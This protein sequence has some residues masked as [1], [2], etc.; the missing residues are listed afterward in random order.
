M[1]VKRFLGRWI[2]GLLV[3]GFLFPLI[4]ACSG[5]NE[6]ENAGNDNK[7]RV[8]RIGTMYG[9][10]YANDPWFRQQ[11]LELFEFSHPNITIEFVEAVSQED[12]QNGEI[13]DAV[14]AM[15][16]IMT[17]DNPPDVVM[18]NYEQMDPFVDENL[19]KPLDA[20]ITKDKF[21]I[22]GIVPSILEALKEKGDGK[23][24]A[25]APYFSSSVLVYNKKM[26][27]E[28]NISYPT[29][30]MTWD[31]VFTMA[32]SLSKDKGDGTRQYGFAFTRHQYDEPYWQMETYAAPLQLRIFD[33]E[34]E[35]MTVNS[36]SWAQVWGTVAELYRDQVLPPGQSYEDQQAF[37]ESTGPYDYDNFLSGK[38]AMS[39]AQSYDIQEFI[40]AERYGGPD[41]EM[42]DWDIVTYPVHSSAPGVGGN[43]WMDGLMGINAKAQNERDAWEFLKFINGEQFAE[44]KSRGSQYLVTR[45]KY[46][47]PIEGKE[48]NIEAFTKIKPVQ[49]EGYEDLYTKYP[50]IGQVFSLGQQKFKEVLDEKMDVSQALQ[51]WEVEGNQ[52]LED[53]RNNPQPEG[54]EVQPMPIDMVEEE[55]IEVVE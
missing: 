17:G 23:I 7:E 12:M 30:G 44:V 55:T 37:T 45:Q 19:L 41:F 3:L 16:E 27:D 38:V 47:K 53:M 52:L 18:L 51:Q 1:A 31:D 34:V 8:L 6:E 26:F 28:A 25:L 35:K 33:T 43:V 13:V 5:N 15:K 20:N 46:I 9:G 48:Y 49:R 40:N 24:Y 29:D 39:L 21:D 14:E 22:D 42:F 36:E 10:G 2:A 54:G 50:N 32:R 4:A 11:Y